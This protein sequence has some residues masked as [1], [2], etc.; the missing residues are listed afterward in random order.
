MDEIARGYALMVWFTP[1]SRASLYLHKI[2]R[3]FSLPVQ[4]LSKHVAVIER[5]DITLFRVLP[6]FYWD[7]DKARSVEL[8]NR[9]YKQD[10]S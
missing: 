2:Y 8:L 5:R 6:V 9:S 4:N 10:V 1:T 7:H 3:L